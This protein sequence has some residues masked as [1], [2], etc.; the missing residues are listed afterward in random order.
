MSLRIAAIVYYLHMRIGE[1]AKRAGVSVQAIRF[2]E[3]CRLMRTPRRTPAGY[4]IYSENDLESVTVIKKMQRFG[5]KLAEIRRVLQL[6]ILPSDAGAAS[7]YHKGSRQCL[8]EALKLG[9]KKLQAMNE[10]IRSSIQIRDELEGALR[11]IR[12]GLK[13]PPQKAQS[14]LPKSSGSAANAAP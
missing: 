13:V 6:W 11:Q 3:R 9:E 12:A 4:R 7:P 5:F 2:Y 14:D 10:Q 8:R 1:L